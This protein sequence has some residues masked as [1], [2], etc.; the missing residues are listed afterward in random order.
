VANYIQLEPS[1]GSNIGS[2]YVWAKN[3]HEGRKDSLLSPLAVADTLSA[4]AS[5]TLSRLKV[6]P[7]RQPVSFTELNQTLGDIKSFAHVGNYYATKIRAA[8]SLAKFDRYRDEADRKSALNILREAAF[9]FNT[10]Q[11]TTHY[12]SRRFITVSEW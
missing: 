7:K 2:I 8:C 11:F 12:T 9:C 1:S 3:Q 5:T 6:L 10:L 4:L